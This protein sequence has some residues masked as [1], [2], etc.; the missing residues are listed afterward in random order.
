MWF[1]A[2]LLACPADDL[3]PRN[4]VE[5]Q[6]WFPDPDGDGFGSREDVYIGCEAPAGWVPY[7]EPLDSMEHTGLPPAHSGETRATGHTGATE[8]TG[9]T[10]HTGASGHTGVPQ[11]TG[12]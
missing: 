8:H 6:A 4:C 3:P 5:R 12:I 7:P 1:A 2:L 11:G 9:A 10:G